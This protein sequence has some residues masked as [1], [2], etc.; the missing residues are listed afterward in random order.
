MKRIASTILTF[1]AIV[2][3]L[4]VPVAVNIS[5]VA[6]AT[7]WMAAGALAFG[8]AVAAATLREGQ[9]GYVLGSVMQVAAVASGFVVPA[10]FVLGGLFALMWFILMRIGPQVERA[11]AAHENG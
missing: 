3:L 6:T 2:V 1:E 9:L 4:A 10:M 7:A 8:C 11:K 5:N